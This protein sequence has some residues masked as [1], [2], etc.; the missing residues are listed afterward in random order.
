VPGLFSSNVLTRALHRRSR[1]RALTAAA[2]WPVTEAK[3]LKPII[4]AKDELAEGTVAQDSQLEIPFYFTLRESGAQP[5]GFF[6]GHLRTAALSYS[7]ASRLIPRI[8]EGTLI[9]VRY[10]PQN[11]DDNHTLAADNESTLPVAIW[12][13]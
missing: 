1:D 2:A 4:V 13:R 5:S 11:P 12:S 6:G 10:N 3:L 7:E 9:R 8:P